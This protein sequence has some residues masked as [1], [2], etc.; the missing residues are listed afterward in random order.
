MP[1]ITATI[2]TIIDTAATA[3]TAA[4]DAA[5]AAMDAALS[6]APA[7]PSCLAGITKLED[8]WGQVAL[9]SGATGQ[10]ASLETLISTAGLTGLVGGI[11][12][13]VLDLSTAAA[14]AATKLA[15]ANADKDDAKSYVLTHSPEVLAAYSSCICSS[16]SLSAIL[17]AQACI[18][19]NLPLLDSAV[20]QVAN[21]TTG[22]P[23][24]LDTVVKSL[25]DG[26]AGVSLTG[27]C[28]AGVTELKKA[29]DLI[30]HATEIVDT[31]KECIDRLTSLAPADPLLATA[32]AKFNPAKAA[33]DNA[34]NVLNSD[35]SVITTWQNRA[36]CILRSRTITVVVRDESGDQMGAGVSLSVSNPIVEALQL[37]G[38]DATGI[39]G[40]TVCPGS[41]AS[42]TVPPSF[43]T[44]G[45]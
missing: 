4:K 25:V 24:A 17:E 13:G 14:N 31:I 5:H 26:A 9:A 2:T 27:D 10:I 8:A 15:A 33:L 16:L 45:A 19:V 41:Q 35:T 32:L 44:S 36:R 23:G 42:I 30:K 22:V 20:L 39:I 1:A 34:N 28:N 18:N 38:I 40:S 43:L 6:A 7:G 21:P 37:P 11:P 29:L 12:T 3:A